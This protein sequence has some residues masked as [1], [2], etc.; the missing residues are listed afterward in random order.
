MLGIF[1]RLLSDPPAPEFTAPLV[2]DRPTYAFGDVHGRFD[3]LAPLVRSVLQDAAEAGHDRPRLVFM[4]DYVDR[5]EG[6]K[7]VI[8]LVTERRS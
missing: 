6:S 3:L 8:D 2:I 5:G 4:G 1:K 7:E